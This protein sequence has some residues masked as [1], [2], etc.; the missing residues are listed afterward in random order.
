M[1]SFPT[2]ISRR[3]Q[4]WVDWLGPDEQ[5]LLKEVYNV[6]SADGRRLAMI[7]ARALVG[8][9]MCRHVGEMG[10]FSAQLEVLESITAGFGRELSLDGRWPRTLFVGGGFSSW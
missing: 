8:M 5:A 9:V 6:V 10:S 3:S 2:A 4:E 1:S 7:G